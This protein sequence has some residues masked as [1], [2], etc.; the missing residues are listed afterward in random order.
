VNVQQTS[1][2]VAAASGGTILQQ[3]IEDNQQRLIAMMCTHLQ[4]SPNDLLTDDIKTYPEFMKV[5]RTV[6]VSTNK[7]Y[8]LVSTWKG[9]QAFVKK[10]S[11]R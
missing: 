2:G 1:T 3:H 8:D 7:Y 11:I 6:A 4:I 5:L 9:K 10:E